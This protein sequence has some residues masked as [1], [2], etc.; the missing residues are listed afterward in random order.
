MSYSQRKPH[1]LRIVIT[2]TSEGVEN[3]IIDLV[4][5]ATTPEELVEKSFA[6]TDAITEAMKKVATA[7]GYYGSNIG[8]KQY[9]DTIR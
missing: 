8:L 4:E 3:Q 5:G 7:A 1:Q 9:P 2:S 6:V